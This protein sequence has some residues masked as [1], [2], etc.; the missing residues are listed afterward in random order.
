MTGVAQLN[1]MDV[2]TS[3]SAPRVSMSE[4]VARLRVPDPSERSAPRSSPRPLSFKSYH[5]PCAMYDT[6]RVPGAGVGSRVM[7]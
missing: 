2:S 1:R 6:V 4:P 5:L 3:G 7:V